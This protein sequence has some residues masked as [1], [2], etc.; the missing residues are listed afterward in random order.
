MAVIIFL[1]LT[2]GIFSNLYP[3]KKGV[4]KTFFID[5]EVLAW[6]DSYQD[7]ECVVMTNENNK[8]GSFILSIEYDGQIYE[9][10]IRI[11][12]LWQVI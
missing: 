2:I 6:V 4:E 9:K 11:I 3:D 10:E 1:V 8:L 5:N 7:N 12:S